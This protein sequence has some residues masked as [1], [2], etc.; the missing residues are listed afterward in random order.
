MLISLFKGIFKKGFKSWVKSQD[1]YIA[2]HI[3]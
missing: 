2:I 3:N 1:G